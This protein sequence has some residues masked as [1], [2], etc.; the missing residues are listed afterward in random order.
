VLTEFLA[1]SSDV[2]PASAAVAVGSLTVA[3]LGALGSAVGVQSAARS[4]REQGRS[5]K[6]AS[7]ALAQTNS[8]EAVYIDLI[9]GAEK[10]GN[11][12]FTACLVTGTLGALTVIGG[13]AVGLLYGMHDVGI[14]TAICGAMPSAVSG[15]LGKMTKDA[16]V[17]AKEY[18]LHLAQTCERDNEVDRKLRV[19]K[20]IKDPNDRSRYLMDLSHQQQG[21]HQDKEKENQE[22]RTKDALIERVDHLARMLAQRDEEL[23]QSRERSGHLAHEL[24]EAYKSFD[25]VTEPGAKADPSG[26]KNRDLRETK[27]DSIPS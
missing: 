9:R 5:L 17:E 12:A 15:L 26:A 4:R 24:G 2:D 7:A 27:G 19:A 3:A 23:K 25:Y 22:Q 21:Q 20:Q 10:R 8:P 1:A 6:G 16:N 14:F 18:F 11:R 13:A